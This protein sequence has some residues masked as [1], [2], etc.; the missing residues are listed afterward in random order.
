MI[1][2]LTPEQLLGLAALALTG[3]ALLGVAIGIELY[4]RCER[5]F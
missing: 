5:T 4:R 1:I 2:E 3:G